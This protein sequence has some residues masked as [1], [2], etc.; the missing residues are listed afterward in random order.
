MFKAAKALVLTWSKE[1]DRR[2]LPDSGGRTYGLGA[3]TDGGRMTSYRPFVPIFAIYPGSGPGPSHTT[4]DYMFLAAAN[5][6]N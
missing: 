5:T 1:T 2:T 6:Y 4:R 3:V